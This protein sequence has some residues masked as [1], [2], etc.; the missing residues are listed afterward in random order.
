MIDTV[1]AKSCTVL[2]LVEK[3]LLGRVAY[4]HAKW[5]DALW[6]QVCIVFFASVCDFVGEP[7][8]SDV[9]DAFDLRCGLVE[10]NECFEIVHLSQ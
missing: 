5:K 4:L 6:F 7:L 2:V 3:L 1:A 9:F 10:V 8:L